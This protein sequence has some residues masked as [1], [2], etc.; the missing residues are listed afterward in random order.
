MDVNNR[1]AGYIGWQ[2]WRLDVT[3]FVRSGENVITVVVFGS[4]KN[5]L[6]PHHR[7]AVRG[8]AWPGFFLHE[9]DKG[10]PPGD[11][12]DVIGYGLNEAFRVY[13]VE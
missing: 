2:P 5:L 11:Q 12:Y 9:M 7:G 10:Q 4:L 1:K 6:G 3:G 13:R 8:S